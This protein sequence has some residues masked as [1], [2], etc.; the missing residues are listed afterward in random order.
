M[1]CHAFVRERLSICGLAGV[2]AA[3][4]QNTATAPA[5]AHIGLAISRAGSRPV[6]PGPR[7]WFSGSVKVEQLFAGDAPSRVSGGIVTFAPGA[8]S[9]WHTHPCGQILLITA[10]EGRVQMEGGPIQVV[11]TGDVVWIPAG[12]KHWH[13]AAPDS[14]MTHIAIQDNQDGVAVNWLGPVT[15]EQYRGGKSALP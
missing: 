10:G 13:G 8:R 6:T 4:A 9:A 7:N 15:D 3:Y 2:Q 12:V 5:D 11:H 1:D 14:S